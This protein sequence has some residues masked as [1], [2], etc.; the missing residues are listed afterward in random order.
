M[1]PESKPLNTHI[2]LTQPLID[3]EC[4]TVGMYMRSDVQKINADVSM[5]GM[6]E[7][8]FFY[9]RKSLKGL[10]P[11]FQSNFCRKVFVC[12]LKLILNDLQKS[13][14]KLCLTHLS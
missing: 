11:H 12:I 6:P 3:Q 14:A 9:R 5:F 10:D 7:I 4:V 13:C 8:K 2:R 1:I